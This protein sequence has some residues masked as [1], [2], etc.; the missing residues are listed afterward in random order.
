MMRFNLGLVCWMICGLIG[1][2]TS[3]VARSAETDQA[4]LRKAIGQGIS[5]IEASSKEYLKQRTCFSCHHQGMPMVMF[6]EAKKRGFEVDE[7]NFQAQLQRTLK[8]LKG[9]KKRYNEGKGQGGRV[10]T[11]AWGLW[12]LESGGHKPDDTTS[13]VTNFLLTYQKDRGHWTPPGNRPPTGASRFASTYVALRGLDRYV[14]QQ[15]KEKFIERLKRLVP[16]W[17]QEV[18]PKDTEDRVY[19][20]RLW[21]YVSLYERRG[22]VSGPAIAESQDRGFGPNGEK[23]YNAFGRSYYYVLTNFDSAD[24]RVDEAAKDLLERQNEDGGW[25]QTDKL[26]SDAYATG[27]VLV[28]LNETGQLPVSDPRYQKGLQFLLSTQLPDGSWKV[29]TRS[30]PFQTY[31]ESGFPHKKSQFVSIAGSSWAVIALLKTFPEIK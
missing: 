7:E 10:D 29:Q 3:P 25:S 20:L 24:V 6:S 31:F 23:A 1:S 5:L 27:T 18:E 17:L 19:A 8:H 21:N 11:A 26:E 9:G 2:F 14:T 4:E 16:G 28:A 12:A 13:A 22:S 30:R 15:Q